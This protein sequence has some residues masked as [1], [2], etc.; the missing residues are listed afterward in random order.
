MN[1]KERIIQNAETIRVDADTIVNL[2][3][4]ITSRLKTLKEL[5]DNIETHS[6]QPEPNPAVIPVP[7]SQ[8]VPVQASHS[9]PEPNP[10]S[11]LQPTSEGLAG[12]ID[13]T[14]LGARS[15]DSQVHGYTFKDTYHSRIVIENS[16]EKVYY[17]LYPTEKGDVT[18]NNILTNGQPTTFS[19]Q[20]ISPHILKNNNGSFVLENAIGFISA[21]DLNKYNLCGCEVLVPNGTFIHLQGHGLNTLF[22]D[23][24]PLKIKGS[25]N[26]V[27]IGVSTNPDIIASIDSKLENLTLHNIIP[28]TGSRHLDRDFY[29]KNVE[30]NFKTI[31]TSSTYLINVNHSKS[32]IY[33]H[34]VKINADSVYCGIW[35]GTANNVEIQYCD[36]NI[37]SSSHPIRVNDF[38][39]A[40]DVS[41]NKVKNGTTGIQV[42]T[43][44]RK[45][46]RNV[47]IRDN[48]VKNC[49]EESISID[50]FGNNLGLFPVIAR[51]KIE[52]VRDWMKGDF[53]VGRIIDL[54]QLIF[55]QQKDN[56]GGFEHRTINADQIDDP[57]NFLFLIESGALEL[58]TSL[59]ERS[60]VINFEGRTTYRLFLKASLDKSKLSK[61]TEVALFT[62]AYN[63]DISGNIVY[64]A[65]P[66]SGQPGHG[67]SLWGASFYCNVENNTVDGCKHGMHLA[68]FGSF[69]VTNP[70][71]FNYAIGNNI[72]KNNF[73]NCERPFDIRNFYGSR[74]G[75]ANR[76]NY[77]NCM[78]GKFEINTQKM[79][80]FT[81][82]NLVNCEGNIVNVGPGILDK[83]ILLN[84]IIKIT[85]SNLSQGVNAMENSSIT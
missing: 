52:N 1:N 21:D 61:G 56:G 24:Q 15:I 4:D 17:I 69:G 35:V 11:S 72:Y 9:N 59:I 10:H 39:G 85:T 40:C 25:G 65:I 50:A 47:K 30:L 29:L 34:G 3:N 43:Q 58:T 2:A 77:N 55:V 37:E 78:G 76:F 36:M 60:E 79:F 71:F 70:E 5:V 7:I 32:N 57:K 6:K 26:S 31:T 73:N 14:S 27:L 66:A 64:G 12:T 67:I 49:T 68:G 54:Q 48:E 42:A 74:F 45:L 8:S 19:I 16:N 63:C 51:T 81:G 23:Q 18:Y 46:L 28:S 80:Q 84:S 38:I 75:F 13:I 33:C 53:V 44:R 82:N 22:F 83:N 62:G 20:S 41:K